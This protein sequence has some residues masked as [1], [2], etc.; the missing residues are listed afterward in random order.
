MANVVVI[1]GAA[2]ALGSEVA[3]H[4]VS[5]GY[6]AALFDTPH[7]AERLHALSAS[8]GEASHPFEADITLPTAWADALGVVEQ[9][10]G[11]PTHAVLTA[12]GWQGGKPLHAEPDA[13]VWRSMIQVNLETTHMSLR[14]VLPGMV[15]RK[16]GSVVL[17]GSRAAER[18]WTSAGAAAYA[19]SKAAVVTLAQ[20]T[21]QEVLE[22]GVRVNALL[23]STLDTPANRSSMPKADPSRWVT[24]SS[25]AEV[26]AFLLSTGARDVT[27]AA[28]PIYGRA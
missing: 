9:R 3:R 4:L 12:G 26:I 19:A 18:P 28:V 24:T 10:L 17:I 16:N 2:G 8:L 20:V 25:A 5:L 23:P 6:R 11:P 7:A 27:G 21:A 22:H 1:T 13:L 15:Q 14:A